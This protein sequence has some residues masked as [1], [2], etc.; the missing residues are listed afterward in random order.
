MTA[1][2]LADAR[3]YSCNIIITVI[4]ILLNFK[5]YYK[6]PYFDTSYTQSAY[7][8]IVIGVNQHNL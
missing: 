4:I 7:N 1:Y 5:T 2:I 3:I 8:R 6:L